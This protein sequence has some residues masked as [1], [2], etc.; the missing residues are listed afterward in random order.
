MARDVSS[1]DDSRQRVTIPQPC[2][3]GPGFD[4]PGDCGKLDPLA[5]SSCCRPIHSEQ[6]NGTQVVSGDGENGYGVDDVDS[7]LGDDESDDGEYVSKSC[8]LSIST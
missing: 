5:V 3:E 7:A 4:A 2:L 1:Y 6:V 8:S